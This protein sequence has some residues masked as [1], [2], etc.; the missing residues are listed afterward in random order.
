MIC[1]QSVHT[2]Q[3]TH[4]LKLLSRSS[5]R[6]WGI[7][8]IKWIRV[9]S[10]RKS[11]IFWREDINV[12]LISSSQIFHGTFNSLMHALI[13]AII[14]ILM[15]CVWWMDKCSWFTSVGLY[16]SPGGQESPDVM[17]K[18]SRRLSD[19]H[20]DTLEDDT[21]FRNSDTVSLS[22]CSCLLKSIVNPFWTLS[23]GKQPTFNKVQ[24]YNHC[25]HQTSWHMHSSLP[26][27]VKMFYFDVL[28]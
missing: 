25:T 5:I 7:P 24:H 18:T 19:C 27:L 26:D 22:S 20:Q 23:H 15:A 14:S 9:N 13:R 17:R 2:W 12:V 10:C 21:T 4:E 16:G 11:Q 6:A 1:P 8:S 28:F 3:R